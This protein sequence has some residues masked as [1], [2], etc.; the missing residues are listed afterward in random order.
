VRSAAGNKNDESI[1][2]T[3]GNKTSGR[4]KWMREKDGE[5]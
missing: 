3:I 2:K 5:M 4:K 1:L